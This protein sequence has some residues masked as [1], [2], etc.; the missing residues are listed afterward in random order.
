MARPIHTSQVADTMMVLEI[1]TLSSQA[2]HK[3]ATED[4]NN[5][6]GATTMGMVKVKQQGAVVM[7]S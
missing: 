7:V 2:P 4:D 3:G 6:K 1:H 5:N